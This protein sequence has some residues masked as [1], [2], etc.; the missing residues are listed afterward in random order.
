MKRVLIGLLLVFALQCGAQ[1]QSVQAALGK[2]VAAYNLAA[3]AVPQNAINAPNGVAGLI[4][5]GSISSSVLNIQQNHASLLTCPVA[6]CPNP[7]N[8]NQ[9]PQILAVQNIEMLAASNVPRQQEWGLVVGVY[10]TG[11]Q[12]TN[13][14]T[15]PPSEKVAFYA[16]AVMGPGGGVTYAMNTDLV[17]NGCITSGSGTVAPHIGSAQPCS[18]P[19]P[20]GQGLGSI[21]YECDYSNWDAN[22]PIGAEETYCIVIVGNSRFSAQAAMAFTNKLNNG[23]TASWY[24]GILLTSGTALDYDIHIIDNASINGIED[25][26]THS[27]NGLVEAGN[28]GSDG[29]KVSGTNGKSDFESAGTSIHGLVATGTYTAGVY[30]TQQAV[31]GNTDVIKALVM[32][33][34]QQ[35][36]F[37]ALNSCMSYSATSTLLNFRTGNNTIDWQM[38]DNGDFYVL[39]GNIHGTSLFGKKLSSA[40]GI[41]A[42]AG[43]VEI[44]TVAGTNDGT[45]K[46]EAI[47]GTGTTPVVLADNIGTGC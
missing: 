11:G 47:A 31:S 24:D 19:L 14:P 9:A 1:A 46:I 43:N 37:N 17:R 16:G 10:A 21:G 39:A 20:T 6:N 41:A 45:C 3:G 4:A 33:P 28:E 13:Y 18:T 44:F 38:D 34:L 30:D 32:A 8:A 36:C 12:S 40:P 2:A 35:V 27:G 15:L 25:T 23:I 42:G 7:A 22:T 26:G 5:D 29:V